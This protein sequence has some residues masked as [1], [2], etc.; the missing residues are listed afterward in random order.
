MRRIDSIK[1]VT[2]MSPQALSRAVMDSTSWMSVIHRESG[3]GADSI[4]CNIHKIV[5][6]TH[7]VWF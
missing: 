5:N 7:L 3:V 6:K 2:G 4:A 1:V